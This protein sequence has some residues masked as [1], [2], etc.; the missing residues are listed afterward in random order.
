[1][2]K[3][4]TDGSVSSSGYGGNKNQRIDS[5]HLASFVDGL[6]PGQVVG[7]QVLAMTCL[8]EIQLHIKFSKGN[9]EVEVVRAKGLVVKTG[10]RQL[11]GIKMKNK[12][13]Y[14]SLYPTAI[15]GIYRY[16]LYL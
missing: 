8:G 12:I 10:S 7:R 6:G 2:S 16:F 5:T 14:P 11:P 15:I 9:L 1:M 3:D 13:L 4:S